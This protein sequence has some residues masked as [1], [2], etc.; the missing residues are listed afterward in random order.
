MPNTI[1]LTGFTELLYQAK[2]IVASEP[3][4]FVNSVM[5][6]ADGSERVSLGGTVSSFKT[7]QP[8]L[9]TS[10]S[11]AM[12][13]PDGD[14]Q[15]IVQD[16]VTI[17]QVA[18]VR[19]PFKGETWRQIQNTSGREAVKNDLFAQAFRKIRNT[20]EAH[21]GTT[22]KNGASRAV[23]TAGTTPFGSSHALINDARR[24]LVDNGAPVE[25]GMVSLVL[26]TAAGTNLRNLTNLYKVNEAGE[27][28]LLRRGTLQ[29]ISG[30]MIKESAGVAVHTKGTLGGS[31]TSAAAGFALGAT[32]IT[33]TASVGTG[34][35]V[36]GD[37][38]S[39][40]ND[41]SNVYVVKTGVADASTAATLVLNDPGLRKATGAQTRALTI[42]AN[43][44]GNVMF[45]RNA[46]ELIMRPPAMPDG[47]D[48]AAD[49]TTIYDEK[50]GL[51]FE[52]AL[53]LGYGMNIID[54]TTFYQAKVW[55]SDF[56]AT[57]LG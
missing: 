57:I 42:A 41:T 24:I 31:P 16:T 1:T 8:T 23:G 11:P 43:Y 44:T 5:V 10:Y 52:V 51:V 50:T 45:H 38:L 36:A 25:D 40:A 48:A 56:I 55:K 33:L 30:I 21:V 49:R 35:I 20:I 34:T 32:S 15:T 27:S 29:D 22:I 6:N 14:D 13:V 26:D 9:N 18:N 2:D 17:G 53:Y 7:A 12:T 47:G 54:I 39:I 28:N 19:I 37:A 46:V 4:A 3:C